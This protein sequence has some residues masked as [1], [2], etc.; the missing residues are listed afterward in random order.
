MI[1]LAPS[2][3]AVIAFVARLAI[4]CIIVLLSF[5]VKSIR[6]YF[7]CYFMFIIVSFLLAG[8]IFF[9]GSLV[10]RQ[11]L[12]CNNGYVYMDFSVG[13]VIMIVC[14]VYMLIKS[15]NSKMYSR[16]TGDIIFNVNLEYNGR[17]VSFAALYDSGN[18]LTDVFTGKPVII[19]SCDS[20]YPFFDS[21]IMIS[22]NNLLEGKISDDIPEKIR[23]LPV[24]TLGN[25][26]ILPA[27]SADRAIVSNETYRRIINNPC[28][29][30]SPDSFIG[31]KYTGLIN[32]SVI[33]QVM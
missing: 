19:A 20:I 28:V 14:A 33:G 6:N 23:L 16:R 11:K 25:E 26:L 17:N 3:N 5:N 13:A 7:R 8:V 32:E 15:L 9:A 30:I 29:A 21:A 4:S 18:S 24:R 27:F 1:I 22:V 31:K 10:D 2:M 12:Y